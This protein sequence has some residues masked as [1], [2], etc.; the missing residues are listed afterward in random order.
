MWE[1]GFLLSKKIKYSELELDRIIILYKFTICGEFTHLCTSTMTYIA[2]S[3][4]SINNIGYFPVICEHRNLIQDINQ[5]GYHKANT[6]VQ[7]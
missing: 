1:T 4:H 7:Y 5:S 3:C 2:A 6:Q